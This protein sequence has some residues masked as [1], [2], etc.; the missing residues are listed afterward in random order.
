MNRA[1]PF[2]VCGIFILLA[3]WH[4]HMATFGLAGGESAAVPSSGG[5]P[6]FTPTPAMTAAVG[7]ILLLVAALVAATAGLLSAHQP[8]RMLAW[9]CCGLALGLLARAVGDFQYLGFF[10]SVRGTPFA[11][12]DT[13]LYSPLCLLLALGVAAVAWRRVGAA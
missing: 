8:P 13:W 1:I 6:L 9:L 11:T 7:V 10:K 5:K 2:A 12:M 3:L 4:F